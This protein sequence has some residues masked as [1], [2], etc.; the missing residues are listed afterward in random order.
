MKETNWCEVLLRN[1]VVRCSQ[2]I[3][4]HALKLEQAL[5]FPN[6]A[7]EYYAR[8][9]GG[10]AKTIH[11]H[12]AD[13]PPD[14]LQKANIFLR[15]LW[16]ILRNAERSRISA[17]PWSMIQSLEEFCRQCVDGSDTSFLIRPQWT[18]NYSVQVDE[19]VSK[20]RNLILAFRCFPINEW[21]QNTDACDPNGPI[22]KI[23]TI[24]FPRMERNNVLLHSALG[25][26]IGHIVSETHVQST[27]KSAWLQ[28]EREFKKAFED[29]AKRRDP[30]SGSEGELFKSAIEDRISERVSSDLSVARNL[31]VQAFREL[32]AD[33]VGFH[34]FGPAAF[35]AYSEIA[36]CADLDA[37]PMRRNEYYPPW[38]FRLRTVGN[39]I[40]DQ[41]DRN[42]T[43]SK[44]EEPMLSP[45]VEWLRVV[46]EFSRHE[47][48]MRS[49][50]ADIVTRY[51]YQFVNRHFPILR[52]KVIENLPDAVRFP[53][54]I[55]SQSSKILELLKRLEQGVP[56]NEIGSWPDTMPAALADILNAGWAF[57]FYKASSNPT[58]P[59]NEVCDNLCLLLLKS[60]ESSFVQNKYQNHLPNEKLLQT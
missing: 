13:I 17:T 12:A 48:D 52:A 50:D 34:L 19:W 38:R 20:L 31:I 45:F 57:K 41:L 27:F 29:D 8:L 9:V 7:P 4:N 21:E 32:C 42:K 6:E 14:L 46:I 44:L 25:H 36:A 2:K 5:D 37:R 43:H 16:G 30:I 49:I 55:V 60:I 18:R 28:E 59:M 10:T 51:S 26:E 33:A 23:Y 53:Y 1:E 24:S 3:A 35:A 22:R 11:S 15:D 54:D 47:T 39:Q 56:P 40:I 58:E